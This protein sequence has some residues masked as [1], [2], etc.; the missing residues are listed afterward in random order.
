[1]K[2]KN[3]YDVV[4]VGGGPAGSVAAR[5]VAEAGL[6]VIILEKDRDIGYPVRCGEAVAH[7]GLEQFIDIDSKFISSYIDKFIMVAPNGEEV[8]FPLGGVKGYVLD[9]KIF[10]YE[11]AKIAAKYGAEILTK[12]YVYDLI[13]KDGKVSGVKYE[14]QGEKLEIECDIVIGADGVES[15]VGR[16]AGLETYVNFR[17]MES[18]ASYTIANANIDPNALYFYFGDNVAPQGYLWVFAKGNNSANVGIGIGG[19]MAKNKSALQYLDDFMEKHFP[20]VQI[21]TKVA[22]GVPCVPTLEKIS[23]P[24]LI[25]VGDAARQVNPLT[26]GGIYSAMVGGQVGGRIVAEAIKSK[27]LDHIFTYDKAWAER[28]GN[29]HKIFNNIKNGIYN[30]KDDKFN[31][32]AKAINKIPKDERTFGKL[33]RTALINQPSLLID[34]AKVFL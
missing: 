5:Y 14:F 7:E 21:L 12:A 32:I 24:G 10:D 11:L 23:A 8:E 6:S 3:R 4:V 13:K 16:W 20:N 34:V 18:A 17:E 33:F 27:N 19:M 28:M 31:S 9:R 30:F 25:L 15:R 22:G 26:G 29:R 1:M 2:I